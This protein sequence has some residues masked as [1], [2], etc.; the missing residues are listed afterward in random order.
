M[1]PNKDWFPAKDLHLRGGVVPGVNSV[2]L[3]DI[4]EEL[5]KSS[6]SLGFYRW[7]FPR[8][9]TQGTSDDTAD[10]GNNMA[11]QLIG[12]S[13]VMIFKVFYIPQDF[14]TIN[15]SNT[16]ISDGTKLTG[17]ACKQS[18][19]WSFC[20]MFSKPFAMDPTWVSQKW[21]SAKTLRHFG[22]GIP[23][24]P[25]CEPSEVNF[26]NKQLHLQVKFLA[27]SGG[28]LECPVGS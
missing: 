16:Q 21:R 1:I 12:T 19:K 10:G 11:N 28:Y 25:C 13:I 23:H 17:S 18:P 4:E 20:C 27:V 14:W 22:R 7:M 24:Q 3:T 5:H 15:S 26:P 9:Q 2:R 8:L 6:R